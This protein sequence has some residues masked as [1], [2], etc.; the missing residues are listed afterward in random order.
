MSQWRSNSILYTWLRS[1][2]LVLFIP[3][4]MLVIIYVQTQQ[5]IEE[6]MNRANS[7][8]LRQLQEEV[9]A[10]IE[11]VQRMREV[12]STNGRV[13]SLLFSTPELT[14]DD[15][16][17]MVQ[18][19]DDFVTYSSTNRYI[20]SFYLYFRGGDFI[21]TSRSY[22]TPEV[23][24]EL[25]LAQTGIEY[26]TWRGLL[27]AN[28][29]GTFV[30]GQDFGIEAGKGDIWF[31]QSLPIENPS[32]SQATLIIQMNKDRLQASL[33]NIHTYHEEGGVYILDG[34]NRVLAAAAAPTF[35]PP[36][37]LQ[38][39]EGYGVIQDGAG[40]EEVVVSYISSSLTNWKLVYALPARVY[41]EKADY[42]RNLTILT[43]ILAIALGAAAAVY[44]SWRN[45]NP[46]RR[47]LLTLSAKSP[48]KPAEVGN[49]NELHYIGESLEQ[50]LHQNDSMN[51]IIEKQNR[52]LRSNLIVRLL[53]GRLES[54]FPLHEALNEYNIQLKSNDFA[55]ILFYIE[56]FS[57]LFREEE[58]DSEKNLRF[59][60]L[61]ISNIVEELVDR[62]HQGWVAE[63]DEMMACVVSFAPGTS[64]GAA[65]EEMLRLLEEAR[66][67]IGQRF[68]IRFTASFSAIHEGIEGIPSAYREAVEAMEYRMLLGAG[69]TID[70]EQI[71]EPAASY[72]YP[73]EKEQQ[74]IN[75]VK[76][77][78]FLQAKGIMDEVFERNLQE[79]PTISIEMARCFMFD[80]ISSMMKAS[81]EAVPADAELYEDNRRAVQAMLQEQTVSR[82]RERMTEFLEQ[83]C[84]YVDARKKSRNARL[85][86]ELLAYIDEAYG[87]PNLSAATLS[88]KFG[89]H[90]SYLSRYFKEQTG[91]TVSDYVNRY[92]MA[93][94][95]QLLAGGDATIKAISE[96]VGIYSISTFTRMFKK[97]EG[98]TP[99]AYREVHKGAKPDDGA[100]G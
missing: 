86:E 98:V 23:Y 25:N 62:K 26:E 42:V 51:R 83:V 1:Y 9:D 69:S 63:A 40:K 68:H 93:K 19:F 44:M 84:T 24:Y 14:A 74:F 54:N 97:Y 8:L 100:A 91:E 99:G 82:M 13:R 92:R 95:K 48:L 36:V 55:V 61:I 87:D 46:I 52:I 22:Y 50:A 53:K 17:T 47:V 75:S 77:G 59:V 11:H 31:T 78:N 27:E 30:N 79:S 41:L 65:K 34:N 16:L 67:F 57:R 7:S 49:V 21:L 29:R 45:Y 73:L 90:P 72:A 76:T 64:P 56:D 80:L 6:E 38:L 96:E 88:D 58:R 35:V 32:A 28:H 60:H 4:V 18:A 20:D 70:Y 43:L 12:I 10:Q 5:V 33:E 66:A 37:H 15:R 85:K 2:A 89:L 94:A 3:I 81:A 71:R 39:E